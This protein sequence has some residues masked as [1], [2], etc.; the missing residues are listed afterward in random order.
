MLRVTATMGVGG[1]DMFG[2]FKGGST[3]KIR[4]SVL[5]EPDVNLRAVFLG[6]RGKNLNFLKQ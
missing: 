5:L 4:V 1:E 3:A 2:R 6:H